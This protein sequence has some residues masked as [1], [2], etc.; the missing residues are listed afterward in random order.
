MLSSIYGELAYESVEYHI[1]AYRERVGRLSVP[2]VRVRSQ[3]S[4]AR[5]VTSHSVYTPGHIVT[6]VESGGL[7]VLVWIHGGG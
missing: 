3:N 1:Q 5:F 2:Q 4:F 6:P 7:P